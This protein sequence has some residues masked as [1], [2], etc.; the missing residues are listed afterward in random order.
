M[1]WQSLLQIIPGWDELADRQDS[2]YVHQPTGGDCNEE[3]D[4]CTEIQVTEAGTYRVSYGLSIAVGT[5]TAS[6]WSAISFVQNT[7]ESGSYNNDEGVTCFD[8]SYR[9]Q[10]DDINT[11]TFSGECLLDLEAN[12]RVRVGLSRTDDN[13]G[14]T[15]LAF[16]T[17]ENWFNMQ[18]IENPTI[19]LL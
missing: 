13:G 4:S 12:D 8:S 11:V 18:K 1:T 14:D 2:I 17:D 15:G 19:S 5:I 9:R 16:A 10:A 3:T 7:T 6:R